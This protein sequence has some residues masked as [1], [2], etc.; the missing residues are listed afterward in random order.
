MIT[1]DEFFKKYYVEKEDIFSAT[2]ENTT[3]SVTVMRTHVWENLNFKREPIAVYANQ[4]KADELI[5]IGGNNELSEYLKNNLWQK[6]FNQYEVE[7][8][9]SK[10]K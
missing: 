10:I 3:E 6:I 4:K 1:K 7:I 2:L 9:N 8:I 5:L